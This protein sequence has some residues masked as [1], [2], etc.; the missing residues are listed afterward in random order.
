MRRLV[1]MRGLEARRIA[2]FCVAVGIAL[3]ATVADAQ[4]EPRAK[5]QIIVT[6]MKSG[7]QF[8]KATIRISRKGRTVATVTTGFYQHAVTPGLYTVSAFSRSQLCGRRTARVRSGRFV[9]VTLICPAGHHWQ[10]AKV[11]GRSFSWMP[12]VR[13]R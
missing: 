8:E 4:T 9:R 2:A 11:T 6:V 5:T 3:A 12:S 1:L 13:D 10:P 7:H